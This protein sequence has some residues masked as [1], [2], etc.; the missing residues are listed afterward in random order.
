MK[1]GLLKEDIT[2]LTA[3]ISVNDFGEESTEWVTKYQTKARLVNKSGNR[4]IQNAEVIYDYIKELE[5]RGYVPINDFD[6][7]L[8]NGKIY[9]I[10]EILERKEYNSKIINVEVIND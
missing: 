4:T 8:W 10:L 1:A 6:R 7:I 3:V 2:V 5:V 9:R